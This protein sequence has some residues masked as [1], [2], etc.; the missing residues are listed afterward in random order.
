MENIRITKFEIM[1]M[2][3]FYTAFSCFIKND[4]FIFIYIYDAISQ[5][6]RKN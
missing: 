3:F 5:Q 4:L 2:S 1:T 6:I